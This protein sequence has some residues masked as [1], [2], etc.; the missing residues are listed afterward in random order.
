MGLSPMATEGAALLSVQRA[1]YDAAETP[2]YRWS[3]Y[4]ERLAKEHVRLPTI[5]GVIDRRILVNYR[6]DVELAARL[7]PA[8]FRPKLANGYAMAG[9]C[10]IRLKQIRPAFVPFAAGI[11]S[12]NAAHRFAV[13]WD[14]DGRRHE[15][16]FIPRRD[17]NSRLNALVGGR[18]FPGE[19][20]HA[21][22]DV[23]EMGEQLS[24][25]FRSDDGQARAGVAGHVANE[26]PSNSVFGSLEQASRF[27]EG[28]ALGYSATRDPS[29]Y[30]GLELR[31]RSWAVQPLAVESV[32]SSYF[33]DRTK[34]PQ[35]AATF[36]CALLM[37]GIAHEWHTRENLCCTDAAG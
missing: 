34:F 12:E 11:G 6:V 10:L 5:Q 24:V 25:S 36:D 3:R 32:Q 20:H 30:D 26:L 16:V 14:R 21:R 22:F 8:P 17:S 4:T 13:E 23:K 31:C 33:D 7:L 35:G 18:L 15:G 19:H 2:R 27:F 29:R 9:I 37:R 1:I 28:G